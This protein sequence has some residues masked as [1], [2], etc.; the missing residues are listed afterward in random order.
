MSEQGG[1]SSY[2]RGSW[3]LHEEVHAAL[4]AKFGCFKD[5]MPGVDF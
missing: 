5:S 2:G 3:D 4:S 1:E